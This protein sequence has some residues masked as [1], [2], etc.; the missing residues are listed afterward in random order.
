M[1]PVFASLRAYSCSS[2]WPTAS[3]QGDQAVKHT[4][5][6][7]LSRHELVSNTMYFDNVWGAC[8]AVQGALSPLHAVA[9]EALLAT[10][11]AIAA[12]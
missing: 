10:L 4:S 6:A 3:Y 1:E 9:L 7:A 2:T 5:C 11:S 12:E 8:H